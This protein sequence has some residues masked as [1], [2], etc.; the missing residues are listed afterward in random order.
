MSRHGQVEAM[1]CGHVHCPV[2]RDWAGTTA[3]VMPSVAVDVRK[4]IDESKSQGAPIYMLHR[5][6]AESGLISQQQM[7]G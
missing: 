3:K 6:S 1:L 4:G 2:D 5:Y 7:V